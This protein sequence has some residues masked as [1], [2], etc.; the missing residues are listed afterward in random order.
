MPWITFLSI[1]SA[2]LREW[3]SFWGSWPGHATISLPPPS[4]ASIFY[5]PP[6]NASTKQIAAF[7]KLLI[8]GR[9]R[10]IFCFHPTPSFSSSHKSTT[11]HPSRDVRQRLSLAK[12]DREQV[13]H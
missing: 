3:E 13:R 11:R 9:R 7:C 1:L 6:F 8:H 12:F 4:F 10:A 5:S 2:I